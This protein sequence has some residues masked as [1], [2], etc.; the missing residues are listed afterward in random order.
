MYVCRYVRGYVGKFIGPPGSIWSGAENGG[1]RAPVIY[2]D[3][4]S[5]PPLSG[6]FVPG[7]VNARWPDE[8]DTWSHNQREVSSTSARAGRRLPPPRAAR[9]ARRRARRLRHP[10]FQ[11]KRPEL[12]CFG[13]SFQVWMRPV[14][15][16]L[17]RS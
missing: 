14:V 5:K 12:R 2:Q 16:V 10:G 9:R 17:P 3:T 1:R 4:K 13:G 11:V 15:M 7:T 6:I 8:E